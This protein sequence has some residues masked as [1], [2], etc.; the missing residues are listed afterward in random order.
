[1]KGNMLTIDMH[2]HIL[3]KTWPDLR[4]R[5]GY[6]GFI[7]LEH[8]KPTA[9]RMMAD[10]KFFREIQAN[11]W[12]PEVRI[13]ECDKLGVDVQVLCTVPVMFSYWAKPEDALDLSR[14]LNDHIADITRKYPNRYVGLGTIPMQSPDLAIAEL[15]RCV[16][17]LD[18]AGVQ[19]G[20]HINNHNLDST[21]LFPIFEAAEELGACI[22]VHPWDMMG[23]EN[24]PKY[25]LPWL[26]GMP[27]ETCL[28]VCSMIF[29]GVFERLP[30]LRVAFAHGGGS[31]PFTL[32]RI[33]HGF[34]VRPD[35]CAIDNPISPADYIGKFYVDSAVHD[36][37]T[38]RY[39]AEIVGTDTILMGS[40]YPFPLGEHEPGRIIHDADFNES[41]K[42]KML[43]AN[44]MEWLGIKENKFISILK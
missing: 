15:E 8:H 19:I 18:M 38:L 41:D 3:P 9:A 35:L 30:K 17:D 32:G 11:C 22:L 37:Q 36:E 40:D 34:N 31:F 33:V 20:S 24:M 13:E 1:M 39:L 27:A 29:G 23:K 28:A 5:Y 16:K 26:V 42:R 2:T 14:I 44:A 6:G 4:E 25:W 12:D 21:E 7:R 43:A 10:E